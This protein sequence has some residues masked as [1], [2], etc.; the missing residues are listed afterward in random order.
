MR[1]LKGN[2]ALRSSVANGHADVTMLLIT[3]GADLEVGIETAKK[4]ANHGMLD[5][6]NQVK[7][8]REE[9]A[10]LLA[11]VPKPPQE[12]QAGMIRM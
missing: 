2:R 7:H 3:Y 11:E 4:K 6:L 1:L 8:S 9:K 5:V 12:M 10:I